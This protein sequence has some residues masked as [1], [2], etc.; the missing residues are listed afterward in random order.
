MKVTGYVIKFKNKLVDILKNNEIRQ[1]RSKR[2]TPGMETVVLSC[3]ELIEGK[4][5][6]IYAAQQ[7]L[8][9]DVKNFEILKK[10]F[11]DEMYLDN[12]NN[13]EF[14]NKTNP[15]SVLNTQKNSPFFPS[16]EIRFF[17]PDRPPMC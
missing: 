13:N 1:L 11:E 5:M 4:L 17:H 16:L 10:Q 6:W 9:N 12:R 7:T 8:V 2:R 14:L 3:D 15:L